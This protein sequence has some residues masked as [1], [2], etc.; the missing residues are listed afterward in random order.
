MELSG[1]FSENIYY[2]DELLDLICQQKELNFKPGDEYLYSNTGY[3]LLGVIAKRV[4]GKPFP[5]PIREYILE[6]LGMRATDFN[7]DAKRIVKNRAIGYSPKGG[8][9]Y[10][11]EMS[12]CGGYGDGAILSTVEDLYLWD[13][14]FYDNKLGNGGGALI[15][16][17]LTPGELNNGE[18]LDYAFGL[19]VS[20]YRGLKKVDHGGAWAGYKSNLIRFPD[21]KFSVICLANLNSISPSRLAQQVADLYLADRFID[22]ERPSNQSE[23]EFINLSPNRIEGITGF[24]CNQKHGNILKLSMEEANSAGSFMASTFKWP[25]Q[26][27]LTLWRLRRL[28]IFRWILKMLNP[29]APRSSASIWKTPSLSAIK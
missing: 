27:Q 2:E 24:Y 15:Q 10:R 19:E 7:D 8:D 14:N 20:N 3:F 26:A 13:Q 22:Q 29:Q 28:L 12:F 23:S 1:M 16:T 18:R 6:P 4:T 11:T 21:Q 5:G 9:G 17:I 25:P